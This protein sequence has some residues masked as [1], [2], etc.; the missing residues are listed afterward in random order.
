MRSRLIRAVRSRLTLPSSYAKQRFRRRLSRPQSGASGRHPVLA[1]A[2]WP[3]Y[4]SQ[5]C[6]HSH[7]N[8]TFHTS[9]LKSAKS[10]LWAFLAWKGVGHR[11]I[12]GVVAR[13]RLLRVHAPSRAGAPRR[14]P[15]RLRR[16]RE[17][18][19]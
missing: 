13:R 19:S 4:G 11:A 1:T 15:Q 7:Y 14:C 10:R 6:L 3:D 12:D 5:V 16:V 2:T 8:L 9:W 18:V 17:R